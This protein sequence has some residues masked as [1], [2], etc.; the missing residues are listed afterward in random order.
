MTKGNNEC[1]TN[2]ANP[3]SSE[4]SGKRTYLE[5]LSNQNSLVVDK[6][7]FDDSDEYFR[8]KKEEREGKREFI[9]V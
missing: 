8:I 5:F 4:D 7:V 6:D 1:I 3:V 9:V 2:I